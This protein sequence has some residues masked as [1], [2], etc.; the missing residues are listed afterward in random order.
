MRPPKATIRLV[1]S[2]IGNMRRSRKR[3]SSP[4]L[5]QVR[6]RPRAAGTGKLGLEERRSGRVDR[7]EGLPP[8]TASP[9]VLGHREAEARRH[10]AHRVGE[11]LRLD[12]HH[13]GEHVAVLAAPE[14]VEEAALLAHRERRRLLGMERT[15]PDEAPPPAAQRHDIRDDFHEARAL[16]DGADGVVADTAGHARP[17]AWW[18]PAPGLAGPVGVSVRPTPTTPVAS[19]VSGRPRRDAAITWGGVPDGTTRP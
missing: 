11:R 10:A 15:E 1:G 19:S 3:S 6:A 17:H 14:A 4:P 7:D 2:A 9:V 12:P 13:E 18:L 16:A 8:R 5:G